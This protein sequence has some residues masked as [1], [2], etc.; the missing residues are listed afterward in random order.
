MYEEVHFRYCYLNN[1]DRFDLGDL[2]LWPSDPKINMVPLLPRMD[3]W[4][5]FEDVR[6]KHIK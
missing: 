5:K 4:T 2:D 3:V 6:L 1:F